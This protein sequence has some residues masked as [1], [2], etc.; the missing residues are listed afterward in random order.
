MKASLILKDLQARYKEEQ[1]NPPPKMKMPGVGFYLKPDHRLIILGG[2]P[3]TGKSAYMCSEAAL[4]LAE[5]N[6]LV[7]IMTYEMHQDK[8]VERLL[9]NGGNLLCDDLDDYKLLNDEIAEAVEQVE[10]R[11]D[12][13]FITSPQ[14][15][16]AVHTYIN[17]VLA[18]PDTIDTQEK[19][20]IIIIWDY[21]QR[22]PLRGDIEEGRTRVAANL[23]AI[24]DINAE[25]DAQSI[26]LSSLNR[27]NYDTTSMEAFK[28]AGD[29]ESDCD[30]A[31]IMRI[32]EQDE[33]DNWVPVDKDRLNDARKPPVVPILFSMVKNRHGAEIEFVMRFDKTRQKMHEMV[34]DEDG[35]FRRPKREDKKKDKVVPIT[36]KRVEYEKP[37]TS[38][39]PGLRYESGK[40]GY[41][42]KINW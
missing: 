7:F 2:M 15:V 16:D 34:N 18:S 32:G 38:V 21:L 8:V 29:I 10:N 17:E 22:I 24:L 31:I 42:E 3:G 28:E 5:Q 11:L 14:S 26:I 27:K 6:V 36:K 41:L 25:Y 40:D 30:M 12:R 37:S 19:P 13:I 39:I 20:K 9:C 23:K 35:I 33:H 4:A 1:L